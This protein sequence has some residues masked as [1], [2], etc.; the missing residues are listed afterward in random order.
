MM[1]RILLIALTACL[2]APLAAQAPADWK[3][4]IDRSQNAQDPDDRKDIT[5]KSM[6]KGFH[7]SGGPAG[8]FWSAANTATGD[9]TA[10]ATFNLVKPSN[11]TNY[12]GLV[13]GGDALDSGNQAYTYFVVA[14]N[15][16]FLIKNRTGENVR[17]VQAPTPSA[18]IKQPDGTGKSTNVLE[19]RVAGNTISYVVNG[20]VVHTT[21]KSGMT[22]KTDGLVGVRVNHMLEVM[23]DGFEVQK[24]G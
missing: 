19:V 1:H 23:V 2:A 20:T 15:G 4:R 21:P 17:D 13:F 10:K 3:V 24:R 18:A 5:F 14:Q 11:H 22:A 6:G 12:Y 9:F 8:V 7:V 16:T